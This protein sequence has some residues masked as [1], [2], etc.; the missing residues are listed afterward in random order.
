MK[1]AICGGK[2]QLGR[3]CTDVLERK[4]E[5]KAVDLDELDITIPSDVD[6][7]IHGFTP[8]V[9]I[10]CAAYTQV[11]KCETEKEPAW[12]INVKG[13]EN[14]A[15]SVQKLGS[16]LIHISTDYVFNGKKKLPDPYVEEDAT[17]PLSYYGMTKLESE[18][19]VRKAT[20]CHVILRTAWL[21]GI[22]GHNF[23]KTMLKLTLNDPERKI[24]VV[25]DQFGS[26]TWSY[27]LALQIEKMIEGGSLGTF[28]AT[29]D[30]YCSWYE[31]ATC[32]L[33]GMG[34]PHSIIPCT[35]AEYPT[36]AQRPANSILE[37]RNLKKAKIDIMPTW[38]DDVD[39]F[40]RMH[41]E[42]LIIETKKR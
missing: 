42:R 23:L 41:K 10:N 12:R 36:P 3:D 32:F 34:I 2:G 9:V 37:N 28:H 31:L 5:V 27:R 26:P 21:Y 11:D 15:R 13:P 40:I 22:T 18:E 20:D 25:N 38:K 30:G 8:D 14:L 1:V 4:H 24:G 7:F 35:T 33:E 19:A 6:A 16:R 39:Q 17:E 29:S